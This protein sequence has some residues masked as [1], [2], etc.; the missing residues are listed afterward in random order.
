M[1][2]GKGRMTEPKSDFQS[3]RSFPWQPG[4]DKRDLVNE[5]AAQKRIDPTNTT[6]IIIPDS[7]YVEGNP[8]TFGPNPALVQEAPNRPQ[9]AIPLPVYRTGVYRQ[10]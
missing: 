1:S 5:Y 10:P 9:Q 4:E 8:D 6:E 7:Y 2:H 3:N